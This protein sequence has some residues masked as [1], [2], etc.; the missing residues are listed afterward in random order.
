LITRGAFKGPRRPGIVVCRAPRLRRVPALNHQ[1]SI[2]IPDIPFRPLRPR[3]VWRSRTPFALCFP[4]RKLRRDQPRLGFSPRRTP[5][6]NLQAAAHRRSQ[7]G[8]VHPGLPAGNYFAEGAHPE[9]VGRPPRLPNRKRGKQRARPAIVTTRH[10]SLGFRHSSRQNRC[11]QT[12][13]DRG[14]KDGC[15]NAERAE[16]PRPPDLFA[17]LK[18]PLLERGLNSRQNQTKEERQPKPEDRPKGISGPRPPPAGDGHARHRANEERR[19]IHH[20]QGKKHSQVIE[21][22]LHTCRRKDHR[23]NE[24]ERKGV[25]EMASATTETFVEA[26]RPRSIGRSAGDGL[27]QD[28]NN[29]HRA[30]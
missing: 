18:C 22:I 25:G 30:T 7:R 14:M 24:S 27:E 1:H 8:L 6:S 23:P 19:Q 20:E 3:H 17:A 2:R 26:L 29:N 12:A 15:D 21:G 13:V 10:S 11:Q 9:F 28:E 5:P 4:Q 16:D